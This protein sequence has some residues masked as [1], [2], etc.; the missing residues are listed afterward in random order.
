MTIYAARIKSHH[1]GSI[2]LISAADP[3]AFGLY[4][5]KVM[6]LRARAVHPVHRFHG[7]RPWSFQ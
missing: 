5:M 4:L 1:N 6:D 7:P 2:W 3:K